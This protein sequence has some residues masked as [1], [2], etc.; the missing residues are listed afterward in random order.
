MSFLRNRNIIALILTTFFI[1]IVSLFD[2]FNSISNFIVKAFGCFIFSGIIIVIWE[3]VK[4]NKNKTGVDSEFLF[5]NESFEKGLKYYE[6]KDFNNAMIYFNKAI[7][8]EPDDSNLWYLRSQVKLSITDFEGAIEDIET[9][10]QL[11][12][13]D[14]K[15]NKEYFQGSQKIGWPDGHISMYQAFLQSIKSEL[16]ISNKR[17]DSK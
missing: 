5:S 2:G 13:V 1:L 7:S 8:Q 14:T 17:R 6:N 12:K 15:L 9:A 16:R 3:E 4:S 11:S 10:I